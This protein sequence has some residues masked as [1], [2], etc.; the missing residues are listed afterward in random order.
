MDMQRSAPGHLGVRLRRIGAEAAQLPVLA[1]A[2]R[3]IYRRLF[4]RPFQN[5]ARY[6][7]VYRTREEARQDAPEGLPTTYDVQASARMYRHQI[8]QIRVSDYPAALWLARLLQAGHRRVFDLGG[9]IGL[10]YY[11][12]RR[13]IDYPADLRWVVHDVPAVMAAGR[14]WATTHDPEGRLAFTDDVEQAADA[15]VLFTSGTLQYLD[16]SLTDLLARLPRRPPHVLVNLVPMH[17]TRTWFTLQNIGFAVCPYRVFSVEEFLGG[18]EELG[19]RP[20][21]RWETFE[22]QLRIPFAPDCDIDRYYGF[23]LGSRDGD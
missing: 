19:Y 9:H 6:Y 4:Q 18:M 22:R 1:L 17:P 5:E 12:F 20:A 10:A 15:D 11:G 7:G 13:Y 3:P 21:D 23:L 14:E 8:E 16:Y 2:A